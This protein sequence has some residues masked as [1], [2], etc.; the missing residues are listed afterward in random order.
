MKYNRL[1]ED[2]RQLQ[3]LGE[4][5]EKIEAAGS[6]EIVVINDE[7]YE[8]ILDKDEDG[9]YILYV[10]RGK[11]YFIKSSVL[12]T[13][14]LGLNLTIETSDEAIGGFDVIFANPWVKN[15]AE[16]IDSMSCNS[17]GNDHSIPSG[18]S[19]YFTGMSFSGNWLVIYRDEFGNIVFSS[20]MEL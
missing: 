8:D 19:M 6:L 9:D 7:N 1:S 2:P 16:S 15:L 10:E 5:V 18:T 17:I 13:I 3:H 4:S 14:F 20:N 12:D 11:K